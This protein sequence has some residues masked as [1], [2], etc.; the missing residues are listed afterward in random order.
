MIDPS[1]KAGVLHLE[2]LGWTKLW[3]LASSLDIPIPCIKSAHVGTPGL[4]TFQR[5]D[6]RMGG[7]SV[8]G[9]FAAGTFAM[10]SPRRRTFLDLRRSSKDVLVLALE[11]HKYDLVMVEVKDAERA[12]QMIRE[13]DPS[14][15]ARRTA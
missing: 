10:G 3:A 2:V 12:L 7:T 4:P 11:N 8:R 9:L 6:L 1:V 15:A 5:G 14:G 13:A